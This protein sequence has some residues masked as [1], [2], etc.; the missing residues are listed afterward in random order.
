M[1]RGIF[2]LFLLLT[3]CATHTDFSSDFAPVEIKTTDFTIYTQQ[4]ITNASA[5]IHI[6][7]EGDGHAF[8]ARGRPTTDPTPRGDFVRQLSMAD[9]GPNVVYMARPCQYIM[10][11]TCSR[12]DWTDGRFSARIIDNMAMAVANVAGPRPIVLIGYSGG[13]MVSGLIIARGGDLNIARWITVAG[14]LNHD[15]WTAHFGDIPLSRSLNLDHLP[16]IPQV[17]Y[18]GGRDRTVPPG[19]SKKWT[20]GHK[21]EIIPDA[22]HT[23]FPGLKLDFAEQGA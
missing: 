18:I 23:N 11:D 4:R 5:P 10:S 9:N 14:V 19:L 17:H 1:K 15:D 7:I 8:N 20:T 6:Y 16:D 22:T 12:T 2:G 3:A 13:A 21:L